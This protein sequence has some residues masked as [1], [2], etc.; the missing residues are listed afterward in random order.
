MLNNLKV[1]K[2]K[3]ESKAKHDITL[4]IIE[5]S[6]KIFNERKIKYDRRYINKNKHSQSIKFSFSYRDYYDS[7]N[8]FHFLTS[9]HR[10]VLKIIKVLQRAKL[11]NDVT[12]SITTS[13]LTKKTGILIN[14]PNSVYRDHDIN[15]YKFPNI[16]YAAYRRD[17]RDGS[18]NT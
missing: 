5:E 13:M 12:V 14:I 15:Q 2:T 7:S 6:I 1:V 11:A 3:I 18:N 17:E 8:R 4:Y 9:I 10:M 16:L